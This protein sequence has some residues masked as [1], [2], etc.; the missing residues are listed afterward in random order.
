MKGLYIGHKNTYIEKVSKDSEEL[1]LLA[2]GDGTEIM[3]Q[4]IQPEKIFYVSPGANGELTEFFYI[5]EGSVA[6]EQDGESAVVGEGE[7][8]YVHN[9]KESIYFKTNNEVTLIYV[10]TQPVFH[11]L[12]N[13][14]QELTKILD[15][16][17]EKDKY[18]HNHDV[19]LQDHAMKI[20]ERLGLS[21]AHLENLVYASLFHDIGKIY[22]PDE[23][24]NKPGHLTEQEF[25]LIKAHPTHGKELLEGTFISD[26]G[27]IIEQH[28]ERL[29]G[30]GYPR[31]LKDNEISVEAR[32]IAIVDSYDAMTSDRPYRKAMAHKDAMNELKSLV[33]KHYDGKI[34]RTFEKIL[35]NEN[36]DDF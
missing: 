18:T 15:K 20:G 31:G 32:I 23:V 19:R 6:Y 4:K 36:D 34:V 11:F 26:V 27:E 9:I 10:S 21:K 25:E 17:R 14:I 8:F 24:L 5:L 7:Y 33:G 3:L 29:D 1:S 12:S 30:S 28:H 13:E 16:I 35:N 2:R 22:V